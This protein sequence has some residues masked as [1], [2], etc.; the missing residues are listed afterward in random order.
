M[1]EESKRKQKFTVSSPGVSRWRF[2]T[3]TLVVLMIV[4]V[5]LM[6]AGWIAARTDGART[7]VEQWM[8]NRLGMQLLVGGTRIGF[9]YVL[10]AENIVSGNGEEGEGYLQVSEARISLGCNPRVKVMLNECDLVLARGAEG[11]WEPSAF[12]VLASLESVE[13]IVAETK[14]FR[15][16]VCLR[17]ENSSIRLIDGAGRDITRATG[18]R[19]SMARAEAGDRLL[20]HYYLWIDHASGA[21]IAPVYN[22]ER[23]WLAIDE[24][25]YIQL[26]YTS[27]QKKTRSGHSFWGERRAGTPQE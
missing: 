9:P 3:R 12:A 17:V 11:A 27:D 20:Y 7:L 25:D 14:G 24:L 13:D 1:T 10:I 19:F 23:E 26:K 22:L 5:L 18:V 21:N 4:L 16:D 6:V 8:E 2:V 15:D